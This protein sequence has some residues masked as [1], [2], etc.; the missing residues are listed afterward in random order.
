M[1][2]VSRIH[3]ARHGNI[4]QLKKMIEGLLSEKGK[5]LIDRQKNILFVSDRQ[6]EMETIDKELEANN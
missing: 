2:S 6:D 3:R 1:V 5:V 4:E